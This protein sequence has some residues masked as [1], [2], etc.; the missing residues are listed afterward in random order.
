[1]FF[2]RFQG[3][4]SAWNYRLLIYLMYLCHSCLFR[5]FMLLFVHSC[6]VAAFFDA[7]AY[8]QA[9]NQLG[10]PGWRR[11][12]WDGPKFLKLSPII[13]NYA[14]HIF[15]GERKI[16]QGGFDLPAPP[17]YGPAFSC[18][19]NPHNASF[20]RSPTTAIRLSPKP[21]LA[22]RPWYQVAVHLTC[23]LHDNVALQR[24]MDERITLVHRRTTRQ[25]FCAINMVRLPGQYGR[26]SMELWGCDATFFQIGPELQEPHDFTIFLVLRYEAHHLQN[27]AECLILSIQ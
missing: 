16:L 6:A 1:M 27:F 9:R 25:R 14:Q 26:R 8:S 20:Q 17:V 22:R 18:P 5:S 19:Q 24:A 12:L 21:S 4:W 2:P 10:T 7:T 15:P 23:M 13:C 3:Y 11:V